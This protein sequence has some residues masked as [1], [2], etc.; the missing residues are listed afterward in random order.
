MPLPPPL[1]SPLSW[2]PAATPDVPLLAEW[3]H[4]LIRDENHRNTMTVDQ[5]AGRL[6]GWLHTGEYQAVLF[7]THEPLAYALFKREDASIYLRQFFVRRDR[8][9]QGHGRTAFSILQK[10][11]W[12]ANV[13]LTV[14]VLC[15]NHGS[16]AFWRGVGYRDYS[17][18]LEILPA[19]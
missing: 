8:R 19:S 15:E 9:R 14:E 10:E 16:I 3:N 11:I 7:S 13:R 4:Q 12:P 5:L 1:A 17:M 6:Q 18:M 2:R